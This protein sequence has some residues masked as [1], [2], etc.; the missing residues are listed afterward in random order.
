MKKVLL[1][2]FL[3]IN[4]LSAVFL[5]VSYLSVYVPSDSIWISSVFG[6]LYPV[7]LWINVGFVFFWSFFKP[8]YLIVSLLVILFGW[9]YIKK[10]VQ[11][12]GKVNDLEGIEVVSYNVRHFEELG[13]D[14]AKQT[15]DSIIAFFLQKTP[16]IICLQEARLRTNQ[17]FNLP[18]LVN[19]FEF[20]NHYQYARNGYSRGMVTMTRYPIINMGEIRF[21]NS[22]NM[23]IFTDV[24]IDS[25]TMRIF[26]LHLQ[27]FQIS[28]DEYSVLE[29]RSL[30]ESSDIK[31]VKEMGGKFKRAL[32]KRAEQ[33]RIIRENINWSPYPVLVCGDF[34]D[35]PFSYTY[36]KVKGDLKDAFVESGSGTGQTY[37]GKLPS[38]RIDFI[39]HS[40][41]YNS[42]NFKEE[43]IHYS[44]HLPVSCILEKK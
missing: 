27:S 20:I 29:S 39:L 13:N 18:K 6:L 44:D 21:A 8:K 7:F 5:L 30:N 11:L 3:W 15:A 33:A 9:G 10:Y 26:N 35:T 14:V 25:D 40:Q 1:K 16:D 12:G 28:P 42:F 22:G 23:A 38:Y 37:V 24:V 34:N 2:I 4:L 32:I 41:D 31:E 43:N 17:I 19:E 36:H